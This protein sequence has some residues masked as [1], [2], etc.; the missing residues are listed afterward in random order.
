MEKILHKLN[1][2]RFFT[3]INTFLTQYEKELEERCICQEACKVVGTPFGNGNGAS[4]FTTPSSTVVV[5]GC[6]VE[7]PNGK[8]PITSND[9]AAIQ[10]QFLW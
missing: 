10:M 8:Y 1:L 2:K 4:P 5:L 9:F 7:S 6:Y 3:I